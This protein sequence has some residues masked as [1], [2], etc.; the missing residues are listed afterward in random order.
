MGSLRKTCQIKLRKLKRHCIGFSHV[1]YIECIDPTNIINVKMC[2]LD[3]CYSIT[4]M[5]EWICIEFGTQIIY[6]LDY[7]VKYFYSETV[8]VGVSL[9]KIFI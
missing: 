6:R 8:L 9:E 3:D 1:N 2:G 7:Y 4:L 5:T